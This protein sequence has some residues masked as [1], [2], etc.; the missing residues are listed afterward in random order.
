MNLK[1]LH[2]RFVISVCVKCQIKKR[3]LFCK[4]GKKT[5]VYSLFLNERLLFLAL[6]Y[7]CEAFVWSVF[8][9]VPRV[10]TASEVCLLNVTSE[11]L[12][13]IG[14]HPSSEPSA[15]CRTPLRVTT[16]ICGRGL[17]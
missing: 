11:V 12:L 2:Q 4:A 8:D 16:R 13:V 7:N 6:L 17:E 3:P 1:I 5:L 9:I 14:H 10:D 15:V